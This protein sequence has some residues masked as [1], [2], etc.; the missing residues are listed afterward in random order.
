M[1]FHSINSTITNS[2]VSIKLVQSSI[3]SQTLGKIY[4]LD[5]QMQASGMFV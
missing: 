2:D 5:A 3:T 1:L 4:D